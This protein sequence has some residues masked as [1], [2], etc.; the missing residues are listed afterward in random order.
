MVAIILAM[1]AA[2][3]LELNWLPSDPDGPLPYS[4]NYMDKLEQLCALKGKLPPTVPNTKKK[5]ILGLCRKL[6]K[7]K[8]VSVEGGTNSTSSIWGLV[9]LA[10]IAVLILVPDFPRQ[11]MGAFRVSWGTRIARL[12]NDETRERARRA[13]ISR[14]QQ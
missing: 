11:M 1:G 8:K 9:S 6:E 10:L 2:H 13:R 14:F 3:A 5:I 7:R 4:Q 12:P